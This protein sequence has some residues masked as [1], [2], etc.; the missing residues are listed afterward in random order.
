[1]SGFRC[2]VGN[3]W[4]HLKSGFRCLVPTNIAKDQRVAA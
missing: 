3:G 1:M 2:Y 4:N